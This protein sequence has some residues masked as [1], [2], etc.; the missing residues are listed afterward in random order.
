MF[1]YNSFRMVFV[2]AVILSFFPC[3]N[4]AKAIE[5]SSTFSS[6]VT[7]S[8]DCVDS[9]KSQVSRNEHRKCENTCGGLGRIKNFISNVDQCT[10]VIPPYD[11]KDSNGNSVTTCQISCPTPLSNCACRARVVGNIGADGAKVT[12]SGA[13]YADAQE[14]FLLSLFE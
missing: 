10:T 1:R 6:T 2:L 7:K 13:V 12:T 8:E 3:A 11:H 4:S 14:D 9:A 5:G